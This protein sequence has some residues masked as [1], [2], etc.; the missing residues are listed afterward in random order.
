M[1]L[2]LRDFFRDAVIFV[3]NQM[4]WQVIYL[5]KYFGEAFV[6]DII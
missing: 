5:T 3:D 4:K 6:S 1:A 2:Q